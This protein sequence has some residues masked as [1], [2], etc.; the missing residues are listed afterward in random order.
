MCWL[1]GL[2]PEVWSQE[3]IAVQLSDDSVCVHFWIWKVRGLLL[4]YNDLLCVVVIVSFLQLTKSTHLWNMAEKLWLCIIC[5]RQL[6]SVCGRKPQLFH[7]SDVGEADMERDFKYKR[8]QRAKLEQ[9][10]LWMGLEIEFVHHPCISCYVAVGHIIAALPVANSS[11]PASLADLITAKRKPLNCLIQLQSH[12]IWHTAVLSSKRSFCDLLIH[13]GS[14]KPG[15]IVKLQCP[16]RTIR[17][18]N[19][20]VILSL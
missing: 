3:K 19:S 9:T 5:E 4:A 14:V 16:P 1:F 12:Y 20:H 2:P 15:A 17:W 6:R 11:E 18:S 7:H 8:Q 10:L 13:H